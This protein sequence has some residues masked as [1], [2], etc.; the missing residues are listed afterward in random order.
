M[1]CRI[2]TIFISQFKEYDY[3]LD[4]TESKGSMLYYTTLVRSA[5]VVLLLIMK[6]IELCKTFDYSKK[7]KDTHLYQI[8]S[9]RNLKHVVYFVFQKR[10]LQ[11]FLF[12]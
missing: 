10:N 6:M 2:F 11:R 8:E 7:K 1:G 4:W 5:A 9:N 3:L 12:M